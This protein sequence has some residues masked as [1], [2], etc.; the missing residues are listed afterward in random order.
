MVSGQPH[1]VWIDNFSK[2]F[3][4][5]LATMS[6]KNLQDAL[7]TGIAL[8]QYMGPP[9]DMSVVTKRG[10]NVSAMPDDPFVL[11]PQMLDRLCTISAADDRGTM[12]HLYDSSYLIKWGVNSVPVT[13]MR[14]NLPALVLKAMV[15]T[16]DRLDNFYPQGLMEHNVG[17]NI[18]LGIVV[19]KFLKAHGHREAT[20][21]KKYLAFTV[22][23]NIFDRMIKVAL[24]TP[25]CC[26][27]HPPHQMMYDLSGGGA[28]F[29][30]YTSV[31]L[32]WWHSYKH[33]V[34][35]IWKAFANTIWAP[36]W[37][38]LYPGSKFPAKA[39]GPQEASMHLLYM[40]RAYPM[41]RGALE[42][43]L[44]DPAVK[45]PGKAM[46]RN[47][48]FLLE[49]AIPVVSQCDSVYI[50]L[51]DPPLSDPTRVSLPCLRDEVVRLYLS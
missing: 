39:Q 14:R 15:A 9:V 4:M 20:P 28:K 16:P 47:I 11:I 49:Y 13:P 25:G 1:V 21:P 31:N 35:K 18:G 46:L 6:K 42:E 29:R 23:V 22:D 51:C 40:S 37:H 8:R 10:F 41:F 27:N 30:M 26:D 17:S 34:A 5:K 43:A 19:D 36:L 48:Q 33:A 38:R 50:Y 2:M 32:A 45:A 24:Y 12:P 44:L 7:W 3:R